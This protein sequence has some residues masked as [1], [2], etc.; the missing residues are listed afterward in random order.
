[1]QHL[2]P[3]HSHPDVLSGN[4]AAVGFVSGEPYTDMHCLLCPLTRALVSSV[5]GGCFR[6]Y[7]ASLVMFVSSVNLG[8]MVRVGVEECGVI[9]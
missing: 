8:P 7:F 6:L 1:M 9:N 5:S 2:L 3:A 4:C